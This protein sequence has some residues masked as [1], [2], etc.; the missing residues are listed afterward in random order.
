M[1]RSVRSRV[2]IHAVC[3]ESGS[4][5]PLDKLGVLPESRTA[6]D[7]K[8]GAR[9]MRRW[10]RKHCSGRTWQALAWAIARQSAAKQQT[11]L[12]RPGAD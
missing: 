12:E 11:N 8:R 10:A 5:A 6:L 3:L 1:W 2:D 4:A 9:R 7:W